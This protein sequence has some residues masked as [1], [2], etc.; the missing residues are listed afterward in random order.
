[1]IYRSQQQHWLTGR[2]VLLGVLFAV[3]ALTF[4]AL[5]SRS[6]SSGARRRLPGQV[7]DVAVPTYQQLQVKVTQGDKDCDLITR[8]IYFCRSLQ[9]EYHNFHL[10]LQRWKT[11][12]SLPQKANKIEYTG[13]AEWFDGRNGVMDLPDLESVGQK[14][15]DMLKIF[16]KQAWLSRRDRFTTGKAKLVSAAKIVLNIAYAVGGGITVGLNQAGTMKDW[17]LV[18]NHIKDADLIVSKISGVLGADG[19]TYEQWRILRWTKALIQNIY[20]TKYLDEFI[21]DMEALKLTCLSMKRDEGLED[22]E[23]G[24]LISHLSLLYRSFH[25]EQTIFGKVNKPVINNHS[26]MHPKTQVKRMT[27]QCTW[28]SAR[29]QK[30]FDKNPESVQNYFAK[31]PKENKL[32]IHYL[33]VGKMKTNEHMLGGIVQFKEYITL[34]EVEK[35]LKLKG[36]TTYHIENWAEEEE[37]LVREL[38]GDR[39]KKYTPTKQYQKYDDVPAFKG[40]NFDIFNGPGPNL[41]RKEA[42][43]GLLTKVNEN[44][45]VQVEM[46]SLMN[47]IIARL[48]IEKE[49]Y[50]Q[51]QN[52]MFAFKK[53]L[54]Q[55]NKL[56][57]ITHIVSNHAANVRQLSTGSAKP[58]RHRSVE[59]PQ[60]VNKP[61]PTFERSN[62]D[63]RSDKPRRGRARDSRT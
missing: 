42:I 30:H 45:Q 62:S 10:N 28:K 48:A 7:T 19:K 50:A 58:D 37:K 53:E 15:K 35:V 44:E 13:N 41:H 1:M 26:T 39:S 32:K 63:T 31:L 21:E 14:M 43:D 16:H 3:T 54:L 33:K 36:I 23:R 29:K 49:H 9:S 11:N 34:E 17:E 12:K 6:G 55:T 47:A 57:A 38:V 61:T 22:R 59:R 40:A 8:V 24:I 18:A 20:P 60:L 25:T 2:N 4:V 52:E 46:K 27:F 51:Q 56:I 5:T